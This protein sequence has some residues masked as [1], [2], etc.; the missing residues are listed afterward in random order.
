MTQGSTAADPQDE[1]MVC[2]HTPSFASERYVN[3]HHEDSVELSRPQFAP[4]F[5]AERNDQVFRNSAA[6][7]SAIF[8]NSSS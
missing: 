1:C 7:S 6:D 2:I 5:A 4:N 8:S 3:G